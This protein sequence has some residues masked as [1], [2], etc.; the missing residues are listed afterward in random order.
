MVGPSGTSS[1]RTLPRRRRERRRAQQET[2]Q[3]QQR[4]PLA[5]AA[6]SSRSVKRKRRKRK[7]K[8]LP[9]TSSH[10][11]RDRARHQQRR[12]HFPGW[13]SAV[14]AVF[15]SYVG[16]PKLLGIIVGM[17]QDDSFLRA[18]RRLWQWQMLG[19]FGNTSRCVPPVVVR[20]M[21]GTNQMDS[22]VAKFWRTCLLCS[23]QVL[24]VQ[25]AETLW[26]FRSFSSSR[27][28]DFSFV[29]QRLL[30]MVLVTIEIPQFRVD[31][32]VDLPSCR[33]CRFPVVVQRQIPIFLTVCRT[34]E[35]LQLL[36]TVIDV[37]VAQVVQFVV[38][39][40]AQRR[41]PMVQAV[42]RTMD[43]PQLQFIDKVFDVPVCRSSRFLGC[44]L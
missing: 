12:W 33:S 4:G 18:R 29:L 21:A 42:L 39:V 28:V 1:R 40:E 25:T 14:H 15:P 2:S 7:K 30:P 11:S 36:D 37:P 10:S 17:D 22:Y 34:K 5:G 16:R 35:T 44:R 26:I 38:F 23:T 9:R 13:F 43:I 41:F 27:V 20:P 31:K 6:S 24:V 19:W 8:K 32:V 3:L